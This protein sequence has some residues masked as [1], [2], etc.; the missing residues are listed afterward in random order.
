MFTARPH[1]LLRVSG[2]AVL[3]TDAPAW[4]LDALSHAPWVVVRRA[5][6]SE[7][8][9]AVG[10]RGSTRSERYGTHVALD[11]VREVVTPEALAHV[12]TP[13]RDVPAMRTLTAL[14]PLL[15]DTGLLWGPTG[16]VG[17]ELAT[18]HPTA[19]PD[20]DLDLLVRTCG[21]A[22]TL[23]VLTGLNHEFR[24]VAAQVDC[25]IETP[26]GAVTLAELV[27]GQ[28]DVMMRTSEGPRLVT[29]DAVP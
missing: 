2:A 6:A 21:V 29:R 9:I 19:T 27:D 17:F 13:G 1:D 12:S 10:V 8:L 25:Q 20:S 3:P 15:D 26:S 5:P 24:S 14:R 22:D 16:S 18:G 23:A 28:P 4:A 7:D 11:D